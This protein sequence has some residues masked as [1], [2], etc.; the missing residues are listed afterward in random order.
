MSLLTYLDLV[1]LVDQGMIEN[2]NHEQI[3]GASIDVTLGRY[4]WVEETSGYLVRLKEKQAPRMR[5]HD[6][7]E[8]PYSLRPGEFILAQTREVF[9]LPSDIAAEF[10]LKSSTARAGL[11]NALATWC[12]PT[13]NGSV[14]TLE[15]KNN[16]QA[17][18]L[19]LEIGMKIGQMIFFRG[20]AVPPEQSYATKG[21]Y[22]ND[23]VATQSKGAR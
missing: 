22:N 7:V 6:L 18:P 13:W 21:Q 14:L 5:K 2:L 10:K 11:D 23:S 3:N 19:L 20:K 9:G 4:I 17:H 16:T 12:D 15:L 8:E 1:D